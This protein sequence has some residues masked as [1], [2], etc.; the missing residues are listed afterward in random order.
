MKKS[1]PVYSLLLLSAIT[2]SPVIKA[3]PIGLMVDIYCP[4][5]QGAPNVITNFGDYIGGYGM[6]NI[7]SQNNP[8][9]FKSISLAHDVPAQL[10]NYYNEATSYNSTTGQV[11]CSYISNNPTEPRFAVAYTL[12]NGKGGSVQWQSGNS[13]NIIF[14]VGFNS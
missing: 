2:F 10:G 3:S 6:E 9:Y 11:T 5:T 13:I 4:T 12:T 8:I 7:L 1:S 14:P